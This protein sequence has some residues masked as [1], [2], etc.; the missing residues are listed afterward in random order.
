VVTATLRH[1]QIIFKDCFFAVDSQALDVNFKAVQRFR[2]C[3]GA[4]TC[5]HFCGNQ[6]VESRFSHVYRSLACKPGQIEVLA[7][8]TPLI[9]GARVTEFTRM[10][11]CLLQP[12]WVEQHFG[13][14][15]CER[16][17]FCLLSL[18]TSA[19]FLPGLGR[20]P[21]VGEFLSGDLPV[22][23]TLLVIYAVWP[24]A[25]SRCACWMRTK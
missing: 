17:R 22:C 9:K 12:F 11:V 10:P 8:L 6:D 2:C 13:A 23:L 1:C 16:L 5:A 4:M 24:L 14:T 18:A 25:N 19:C 15:P 20:D 3:K 7:R 21:P